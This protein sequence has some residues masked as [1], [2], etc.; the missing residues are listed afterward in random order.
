[1]R[2]NSSDPGEQPPLRRAFDARAAA[3]AARG[4]R[5]PADHPRGQPVRRLPHDRLDAPEEGDPT[6]I[7]FSH[8]IDLRSDTD[9]I[10]ETVAGA[11]WV[12]VSCHVPVTDAPALVGSSFEP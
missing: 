1:M 7:P 8:Y 4:R 12:C 5:F 2:P 3:R 9:E 6:P 10:G 11:R